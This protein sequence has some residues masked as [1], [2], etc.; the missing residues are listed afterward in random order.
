M[1]DIV[2]ERFFKYPFVFLVGFVVTF[3]LTPAVSRLAI[4]VGMVDRPGQRHIHTRVV[5]RCGLSVFL[6]FHAA[7]AS[8]FLLPWLPF[9]S[10]LNF[11]WWCRFFVL[12]SLLMLVG[13]ADD[14][15]NL[16]PWIK[17]AGQVIVGILAYEFGIRVGKILGVPLSPMLDLVATVVWFVALINAFNLIDGIDGLAAGLAAIAA[18]GIAGSLMFRHLPGDV[19]VLFGFIGACLAFLR[20]NFQPASIFLGDS[21][22]MFLGLTLAAIA[23][24]T[25]AKGTALTAI[26]IPLLAVGI[27]LLDTLLAVWRRTVRR[28]QARAGGVGAK[29]APSLF[30]GDTD[31]LHHRLLRSGFSHRGAATALYGLNAALV[32]VGLLSAL[33][34]SQAVG[35][36]LLAFV[37]GTFVAV[38]FLVG[39]ELWDSGV[40]ISENTRRPRG[41]ALSVVLLP[42]WDLLALMGAL[43]IGSL[44]GGRGIAGSDFIQFWFDQIPVWVGVPF[45]FLLV[46]NT[47]RRV[48]S[49]ARSFEYVILM[50]VL[51]AGIFVAC[52]VAVLL[53][54]YHPAMQVMVINLG[55]A[56]APTVVMGQQASNALAWQVILYVVAATAL[57]VLPRCVP[58]IVQDAVGGT[59]QRGLRDARHRRV[60]LYGAGYG[61]SMVLMERSFAPIQSVEP[62]HILG[63]LDDDPILKGRY[64]AGHRVIGGIEQL[65]ELL[66]QQ[67]VDRITITTQ[68]RPDVLV[69]LTELATTHRVTL[70]QWRTIETTLVRPPTA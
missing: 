52:G 60:I 17:L 4:A 40:A 42:F 41:R 19:L 20:Y 23:P 7:C 30:A 38:K 45:L 51:V 69:R 48:W 33:Y 18:I 26:A 3:L 5:P 1:N 34:R 63:L 11:D 32:A 35:I 6:G 65:A 59:G 2:I 67:R 49:R 8:V 50:A 66:K 14:R 58:R 13:L 55:E 10:Q 28:F 25:G 27:P 70:L 62:V 29:S 9:G 16:K 44:S 36:Y 12:S 15:W 64:I 53:K 47:Y 57:V 39:T 68:L 43:A 61:A 22:S 37:G 31:H 56:N 46:A 24:G 21:G 54:Q